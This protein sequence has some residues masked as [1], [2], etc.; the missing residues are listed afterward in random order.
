[1]RTNFLAESYNRQFSID[2]IMIKKQKKYNLINSTWFKLKLIIS[3]LCF[4]VS[5]ITE[6]TQKLTS[7]IFWAKNNKIVI[8][9]N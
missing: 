9:S 3:L 6:S 1:M 4:K 2:V 5:L 7:K 8:I